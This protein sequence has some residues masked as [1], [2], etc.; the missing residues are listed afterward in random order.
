MIYIDFTPLVFF[1][2]CSTAGLL[3]LL[4][5]Q[6]EICIINNVGR[7]RV[8]IYLRCNAINNEFAS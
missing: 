7:K 4:Q 2:S 8:S 6:D 3:F 1:M 5:L